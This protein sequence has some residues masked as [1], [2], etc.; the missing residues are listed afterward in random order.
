M[1]YIKLLYRILKRIFQTILGKDHLIFANCTLRYDY[2]GSEYGG[3]PVIDHIFNSGSIIYSFGIGN[4]ISWDLAVIKRYRANVFA[5]DPTPV[6]EEW[7]KKQQLP[8]LFLYHKVGLS[9]HNGTEELSVPENDLHVSYSKVLTDSSAKTEIFSVN[10][11][12]QLMQINGHKS[13][14]VL[15]MDIEGGEYNVIDD[16]INKSIF[17]TI[18]LV[19]FHHR[20]DG[21]GIEKTRNSI[22]ILKSAGY[23]IFYVS[24]NGEEFGFIK[25]DKL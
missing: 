3:W 25:K 24:I 8:N 15:K 11:L 17:P 18:I 13:I 20:F 2:L 6:C 22:D 5:F 7:I 21:V 19:E 4:D 9:D 16:I 10:T 23:C 14:D 1:K 12:G